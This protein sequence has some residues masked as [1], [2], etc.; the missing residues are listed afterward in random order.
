MQKPKQLRI[1]KHPC[2]P[3]QKA[4]LEYLNPPEDMKVSEWAERYRMLD[5]KTSAEPGPWNNSRTPYLVEIMDELLNYETEEI[6][7][8]KCTQ[9]GGTEV[10]LNMLGY[11]AQQDPSPIEVVYPTETLANSISEK[12]I[13][14]MIENTPTLYRKYDKNSGNLEL[15]FDDM[16]IK[17]VWSNSPSGLA[18]FAM[19]Y[20]FL[21][22]VDKYPGASK[23]EADPISLAKERTKTF[24]N[25]KV[26]ITSTPT[27]RTNHIWKAKEGADAE[28]H[29]FV[30]CPHC[31]EYI[32]LRFDN[33]KW[34]GKDK[35]LV[36]A[37]GEDAIKE[38]LG[39]FEPIDDSEGLSDADRAEFAFYV[40]QE[41]GCV[42]SDAQK[43][44]AVKKGHWE[45]VRQTTRFVK[46]VC[47]WINTLYSPFVRFSEI[48]K[49]FMESKADPEKLQNFV[50]SWL[51][52]PW[53]DT[54]LK[55]SKDLVMERQTELPEFTVPDWTKLLTA[56]V[57]VQEN[58]VYWTIRAWGDFLTSQNIAH[59]Q[60]YSFSEIE[61]IMNLEYRTESGAVAIVN[62]CLMDSGY[63]ADAVYDFCATNAEWAKPAKGSS[64]P[65]Q[66]HFKL[67][68]VNKDASKA[69]GMDLVIVD[70]GKYKDMIAS[71]MHRKNGN[72]SW[73][74]YKGC[75]EEYAEQV[76]AEHKILVKNGNSKPR[77]EWV[78]K[79]S[80]A[81]NHYLDAEVYAMAAADTLGVRMLHLQNIQEEPKEPKK[82]QY[83]PEEEWINQNES[84]L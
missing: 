45:V 23:K 55:T 41:C 61:Q 17:L 43:Q 65:M 66:S 38:K 2:K 78:P 57:D 22:E 15:D 39:T 71:R 52:E 26:Y 62:L 67:S 46:K 84:W 48:A 14:P 69:Y 29:Y 32:E 34:P 40:C 64:N 24:R 47:F 63:E 16:F 58:S 53:E 33:L 42:I 59:G 19:K 82:E 70:G 54:K 77:L 51:A 6:I 72:G 83:T 36:D 50:N 13:K 35:D 12:R 4:A 7:F 30:P 44:Q 79:H 11:A 9:V 37:Y 5:S 73:M 31:G 3:Y 18:S 28:K 27:I 68:T 8:C 81:D 21:D 10:E 74:V 80:H 25:S 76:T 75:D 1:R 49:E 56:G 60:A 20:L